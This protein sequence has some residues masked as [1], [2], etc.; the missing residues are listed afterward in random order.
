MSTSQGV[1]G[2]STDPLTSTNESQIV[3]L[4][5]TRMLLL[6]RLQSEKSPCRFVV[7]RAS[8]LPDSRL[9]LCKYF[10]TLKTSVGWAD[11][12]DRRKGKNPEWNKEFLW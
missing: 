3:K 12:T 2:A 9:G 5:F 8:D 7:L 11:D 4:R 6:Y 1:I 10:V